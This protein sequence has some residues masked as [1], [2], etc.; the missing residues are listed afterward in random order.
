MGKLFGI[1]KNS[2]MGEY[3]YMFDESLNTYD[4]SYLLFLNYNLGFDTKNAITENK[5]TMLGNGI[6]KILY[7]YCNDKLEKYFFS[8]KKYF[9]PGK[10]KNRFD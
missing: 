6:Y 10:M 5:V 2:D 9:L 7:K 8:W 3:H 4:N 1:N